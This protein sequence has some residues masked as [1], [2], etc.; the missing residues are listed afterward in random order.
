[1]AR[2]GS[3]DYGFLTV[4]TA[5]YAKAELLFSVEPSA[6]SPPPKVVSALVRLTPHAEIPADAEDFLK[7]AGHCFRQK[8]KTLR[9]NLSGIYD[10]ALLSDV[11]ETARRGEELSIEELRSLYH[12]VKYAF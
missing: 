1:V 4:E 3:R 9:N 6:F 5:L 11:P 10:R 8:R 7:F 2:A 12:R